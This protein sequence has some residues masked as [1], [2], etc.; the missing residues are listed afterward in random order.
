M[1][2][3]PVPTTRGF[4]ASGRRARSRAVVALVVSL[5]LLATACR[6]ADSDPQATA[7]DPQAGALSPS[8]AGSQGGQ[9]AGEQGTADSATTNPPTASGSDP[10]VPDNGPSSPP[11]DLPRPLTV[12]D[13]T[14]TSPTLDSPLALSA[15]GVD[16][17]ARYADTD[18]RVPNYELAVDIN[19]ETG[20]VAG[21]MRALVPAQDDTI[22]F[23]VFAGMQAFNADLEVRN[24]TVN[25]SAVDFALDT[26][27]LSVP[28]DTTS[29]ESVV[30]LD[31]S[32]TID[33]MAANSGNPFSALTGES[34][35]PDQVGLLG[36]TDSG[37]QL[38]HWFPVWLPD[39]TR[40]DPDPSGFGDIGAFPAA[41]IC[42]TITVPSQYQVVT[43][44]ARIET[45]DTSVVEA[46]TGLRDFAILVSDDLLLSAQVIQGV[47]IRVWGPTDNPG[48]LSQVMD[49]SLR[50]FE[51]LSEA[52]GPYPWKEIDVVSAP[53]GSGVG[54]MEWPGTIW[55]EQSIFAG[56]LPGFGDFLPDTGTDGADSP[57]D[58]AFAELFE[59]AGGLALTTTLEWTIAH[60]LGHE[61]WHATVG[62]DSIASPA[63]D[64][65]LA[66][67]AACLAMQTIHPDD[68]LAICDAQ[69]VDQYAQARAFGVSDA[70]AEQ[71]TDQ[72]DSALQYGAVVYGKAPG[73]YFEAAEVMGWEPLTAAL[74][75]FIEAN[76]FDL[77]AT[78]ALRSHLIDAAGDNG[79][80]IAELW[81]R[82][83]R[84]ERGDDD[85]EAAELPG[86]GDLNFDELLGEDFNLDEL[87]GEDFDLDELLD[88]TDLDFDA[89]LDQ[90]LEDLEELEDE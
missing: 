79:D 34:L 2:S 15:N 36:R 85:I 61:W 47:E 8:E 53:L 38:G 10:V 25:G 21:A 50:S 29:D 76:S 27:L 65:P 62:N 82:W 33:Q 17:L 68:W 51:R 23:R 54:G 14:C 75:S 26:A 37:M 57:F 16:M 49:H 89:L 83:F 1:A 87:L 30:E 86:L 67:F 78:S 35:Q 90:A 31:F 72:F 19:P 6:V 46:G 84:E 40:T 18:P 12:A 63:V 81:D 3:R 64:E 55:I 13:I 24:V 73:F 32:F 28:A 43:G 9:A 41:N 60:E 56:G 39:G 42:A 48:A 20:A 45:T 70:P 71:A 74:R 88:G 69:T 11:S 4:G 44:G 22:N 66:Q 77:V 59:S 7:I 58:E 52:F 5:A 80:E